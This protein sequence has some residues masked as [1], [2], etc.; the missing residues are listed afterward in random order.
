MTPIE[1]AIVVLS[2]VF[3]VSVMAIALYKKVKGK[4]SCGGG[5]SGCPHAKACQAKMAEINKKQL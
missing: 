1:I 4:A 5:C 2:V 3:V